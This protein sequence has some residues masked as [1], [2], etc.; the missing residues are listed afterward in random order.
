MLT[1][2]P[3]A[4]ARK[5]GYK[6]SGWTTYESCSAELVKKVF[7]WD[8]KWKLVLDLGVSGGEGAGED[9]GERAA[10]QRRWPYGPD[11]FDA[12]IADKKFTNGADT[13]IVKQLYRTMSTAQ[14][15]GITKLDFTGIAPPTVED[16]RRLGTCL[17]LCK[18]LEVLDLRN[19]GMSPEACAAMLSAMTLKT[20]MEIR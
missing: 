3:S 6:D 17:D 10:K 11:A 20:P 19:V 4:S 12:L 5:C 8:A 9:A 2:L 18:S 1:Q 13:E 16:G 7:L 15:R 14:L